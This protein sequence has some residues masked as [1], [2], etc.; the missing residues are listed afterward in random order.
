MA[1]TAQPLVEKDVGPHPHHL[2]LQKEKKLLN[3]TPSTTP[4]NTG[5]PAPPE[6]GLITLLKL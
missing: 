3:V 2:V 6:K 5:T 4:S 1:I